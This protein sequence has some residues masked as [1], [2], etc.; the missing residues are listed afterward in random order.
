MQAVSQAHSLTIFPRGLLCTWHEQA[1][2]YQ[3]VERGRLPPP[4]TRPGGPA[5]CPAGGDTT[6]CQNKNRYIYSNNSNNNRSNRTSFSQGILRGS[7]VS[8][9]SSKN[10]VKKRQAHTNNNNNN[11]VLIKLVIMCQTSSQ[12]STELTNDKVSW[13]IR[14]ARVAMQSWVCNNSQQGIV[15]AHL[16]RLPSQNSPESV[17]TASRE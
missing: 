13:R 14:V 17:T 4:R 3:T 1:A 16:L 8:D 6:S 15:A 5:R 9:Q 7:R 2:L 11:S 10:K 12:V